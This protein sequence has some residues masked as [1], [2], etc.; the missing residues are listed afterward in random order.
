MEIFITLTGLNY[1]MGTAPYKVGRVLRLNKDVKNEYDNE[2]ISVEL[3]FIGKVGYVA[4]SVNTVY[5]GTASAGNIYNSF[6]DHTYAAVR[7]ITHSGV[8]A[9]I[10]TD[11]EI[12]SRYD[13]IFDL[14]EL[15]DLPAS[16]SITDD[17]GK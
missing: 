3:P 8:I 10:I 12:I 11:S 14:P 9:S 17:I 4:N 7:F 6:E 16:E 13:M 15:R 5:M 1:Y 2:A